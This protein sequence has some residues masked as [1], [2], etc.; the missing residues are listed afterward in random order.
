MEIICSHL[1]ARLL[2]TND[3]LLPPDADAPPAP[4]TRF[5]ARSIPAISVEAYLARILRYAPCEPDVLV[6]VLIHLERLSKRKSIFVNSWNV[7]RLLITSFMIGAKYS[8]DTF[9]T[10]THY[11]KVSD[12]FLFLFQKK[13]QYGFSHRQWFIIRLAVFPRPS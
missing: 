10:N 3:R 12:L 7:H 1:L 11:A 13:E 6:L 9:F 5:D 8:S 2:E 4:V